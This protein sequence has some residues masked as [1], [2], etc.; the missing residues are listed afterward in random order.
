MKNGKATVQGFVLLDVDNA[1]LNNL[2]KDETTTFD[3]AVAVK[4]IIKNGYTY[5]YISG[6]AWRYWWRETLALEFGWNLSP[7]IRETKVAYTEANPI[8]YPDDDVFGYMRAIK[9]EKGR[10]KDKSA[11]AG[12]EEEKKKEEKT[13]TRLSPLKNSTLIAVAPTRPANEWSVMARAQGD[14]VPY[15]KQVYACTMKGMFSLDLDE[16]G[17]FYTQ[18]RS[19]FHNLN[20]D[21]GKAAKQ[22]NALLIDDPIAKD[23]EGKPLPRYRMPKEVRLQRAADTIKALHTIA[24]GAKR[25]TNLADVTPKLIILA[26]QKGGNHPFS[27]L[28]VADRQ[29]AGFSIEALRDVLKDYQK[30]FLSKIYIGRRV[31]FMDHLQEP[32]A[33][34]AQENSNV[35]VS[36]VGEAIMTFADKVVPEVLPA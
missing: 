25:T 10:K 1:A 11:E 15:E 7:V 27:H 9:G 32:L 22:S 29:E 4:K 36:S 5:P 20:E 24:G 12:E 33:A 19:G 35:V 34:L 31:G 6:Q 14:P 13:L 28:A 8:N 30:N 23:K 2:G 16:V 21:L 18:N 26:A 3:N 17:T